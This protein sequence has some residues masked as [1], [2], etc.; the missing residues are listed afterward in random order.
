M[1]ERKPDPSLGGWR[2][3]VVDDHA[4]SRAAV[5]EAM[6]A[7]GGV[8]VAEGA[9]AERAPALVERCRPDAVI[10][11]VGLPDGDG[12]AA[13]REI[14][15]RAPCPI[16]LLTSRT[17][18]ALIDRAGSAGV[19]AFLVK[20]LR[21]A[22]LGPALGLAVARFREFEAVRRENRELKK[23]LESRKLVERAKGLLMEREGL[24]EP[25]AFRRIQ[26][27]SME[28]RRSMAEVAEAILLAAVV[29]DLP[30]S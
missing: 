28:S 20:P 23:A 26:R 15:A 3:V 27:A 9:S 17:E 12:V 22:E 7:L 2:V 10:L 14:M 11:A 8:I 18:P 1:Q 13:A 4:P 16:V 30:K 19:M 5:A 21:A 24:S 25:E 29:S 6:A